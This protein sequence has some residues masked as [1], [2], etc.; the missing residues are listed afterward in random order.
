[1]RAL[2]LRRLRAETWLAVRLV[3]AGGWLATLGERWETRAARR[4]REFSGE[5]FGWEHDL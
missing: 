3:W 4:L 5:P 2:R 1:M